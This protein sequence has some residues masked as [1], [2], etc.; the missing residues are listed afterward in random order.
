MGEAKRRNAQGQR[1]AGELDRRLRC[2]EFGPAGGQAG[3]LVVLDK[4]SGGRDA[5]NALRTAEGLTGLPAL[6]QAEPFRLWEASSLFQFLVLISGDG[7]PEQRS[8][9]AAGTQR[10]LEDVLPRAFGRLARAGVRPGIVC[11]VDEALRGTVQAA[12]QRLRG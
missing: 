6:L 11:G 10:L 5:V 8:L 9:L 1:L 7:T 3:Y 12:L 4:S 2:G